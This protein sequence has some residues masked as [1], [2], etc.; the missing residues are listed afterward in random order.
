MYG[1]SIPL[2]HLYNQN[3]QNSEN[4]YP[5]EIIR[6]EVEFA[7]AFRCLIKSLYS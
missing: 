5:I 2:I 4:N 6:E 1:A 7:G 3:D